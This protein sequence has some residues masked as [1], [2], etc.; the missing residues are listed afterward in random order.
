MM[1][2]VLYLG[3]FSASRVFTDSFFKFKSLIFRERVSGGEKHG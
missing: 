1:C 2:T 3:Q